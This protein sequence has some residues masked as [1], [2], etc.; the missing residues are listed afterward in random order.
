MVRTVRKPPILSVC[1]TNNVLGSRLLI[2]K[3]SEVLNNIKSTRRTAIA[4]VSKQTQIHAEIMHSSAID[5]FC[6]ENRRK[7]QGWKPYISTKRL[8]NA[9]TSSCQK[10]LQCLCFQCSTV[11][12]ADTIYEQRSSNSDKNH[13][14][15][16]T[17]TLSATASVIYENNGHMVWLCFLQTAHR[18]QFWRRNRCA[19][20]LYWNL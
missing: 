3:A 4:T 8:Q 12:W 6:S 11:C 20:S 5:L 10:E 13:D 9:C 14:K 17:Q 18:Y 16:G 1:S 7:V 15:S 19:L 2:Y